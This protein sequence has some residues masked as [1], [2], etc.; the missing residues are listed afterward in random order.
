[1]LINEETRDAD[2]GDGAGV[3]ATGMQSFLLTM[4]TT[5]ADPYPH[6]EVAVVK[7]YRG[8]INFIPL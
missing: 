3:M 1:M 8:Q 7:R 4:M 2:D 5:D 6:S